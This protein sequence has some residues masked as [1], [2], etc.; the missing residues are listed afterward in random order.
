VRRYLEY[1]WENE[2]DTF[3]EKEIL[4]LLSEPLR[5]EIYKKINGELIKLYPLF[6]EKYDE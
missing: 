5:N 2:R 1:I 6:E 4:D 3:N